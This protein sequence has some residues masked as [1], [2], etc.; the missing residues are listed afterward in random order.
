MDALHTDI[1]ERV[2]TF[3]AHP[4][5]YATV[6]RRFYQ[7]SQNP[8]IRV[9]SYFNEYGIH[10]LWQIAKRHLPFLTYNIYKALLDRGFQNDIWFYQVYVHEVATL[11]INKNLSN[12]KPLPW[13]DIGLIL[14]EGLLK[15]DE[16]DLNRDCLMIH[17]FLTPF[18]RIE[19]PG[20]DKVIEL[21]GQY[22]V[23]P[24][25]Q[26]LS[27]TFS[28]V[29]Y[30]RVSLSRAIGGFMMHLISTKAPVVELMIKNGVYLDALDPY[31]TC[32]LLTN[33][34]GQSYECVSLLRRLQQVGL[35]QKLTEDT[36]LDVLIYFAS[37]DGLAPVLRIINEN[38]SEALVNK[39][40]THIAKQAIQEMFASPNAWWNDNSMDILLSK[41]PESEQFLHELV[42]NRLRKRIMDKALNETE[43]GFIEKFDEL[44]SEQAPD[45]EIVGF[46]VS[47]ALW[48]DRS[49]P[50]IQFFNITD[51]EILQ[52]F[53]KSMEEFI[54]GVLPTAFQ[55]KCAII[56]RDRV[57][58]LSKL[59]ELWKSDSLSTNAVLSSK[60]ST[61]E[62]SKLFYIPSTQFHRQLL[63]ILKASY[64]PELITRFESYLSPV[65]I[66]TW[67]DTTR[68]SLE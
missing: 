9:E 55:V 8:R 62:T 43:H 16:D 36:L 60:S 57:R 40:L 30:S 52:S 5:T 53:G 34:Y 18:H 31:I 29:V 2:F 44:L 33:E 3:L 54:R 1:L 26:S 4:P 61:N 28:L 12:R 11:K 27:H 68:V 59:L 46:Y 39:N 17:Q 56:E 38:W 13:E 41:I 65:M 22:R 49:L 35:C 14:E 51:P 6:C 58:W 42:T 23:L 48:Q 15:Y 37:H 32:T 64:S 21:L 19:D 45:A 25:Y 66:R 24:T 10:G 47:V 7:I 63:A 20:V 67:K 50:I